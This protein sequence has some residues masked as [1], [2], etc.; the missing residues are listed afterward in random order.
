MHSSGCVQLWAALAVHALGWRI[1]YVGPSETATT[2]ESTHAAPVISTTEPSWSLRIQG[3][4]LIRLVLGGSKR[5]DMRSDSTH[6]TT[7]ASQHLDV[8]GHMLNTKAGV[9]GGQPGCT[10]DWNAS[11]PQAFLASPVLGCEF[12]AVGPRGREHLLERLAGR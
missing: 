10:F 11:T 3:Q 1:A 5:V 7:A 8:T 2:N 4:R 6:G 9:A 12:R